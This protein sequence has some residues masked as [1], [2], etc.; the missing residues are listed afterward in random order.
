MVTGARREI[1]ECLESA[2]LETL[3]VMELPERRVFPV[4]QERLAQPETLVSRGRKMCRK[5][6]LS[7]FWSL[8]G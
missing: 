4:Y 2:P 8:F 5:C 6:I 3:A 7:Q 1:L